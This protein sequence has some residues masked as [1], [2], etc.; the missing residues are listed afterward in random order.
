MNR[1]TTLLFA[2]SIVI[3]SVGCSQEVTPPEHTAFDAIDAFVAQ[4][5]EENGT[6]GLTLAVTSRDALLYVGTY[7]YADL[8]LRRPV[9]EET[10]FQIGSITKSFTALALMH[11]YDDGVFDPM[12]PVEDYLP[13]FSVRT[14]YAPIAG[15]HLLS[16]TAG[17]PANRDDVVGSWYMPWS[18]REQ[19]TAWP[20][21]E[22]FHY[23]NVG[24]QALH[25]LLEKL[26]GVDY[27]TYI[28]RVILEALD[29]HH[30]NP[31]IRL[32]SRTAQAVGYLQPYDDRPPH[33]SR[34]LVEAPF[35]EYGIGDGSIQTTAADMAAYARM[36]LNRGEGPRGRIVSEEAFELFATSHIAQSAVPGAIGYGYGMGVLTQGD[37]DYLAH[38][39]GMIGL[40]GYLLADLT[41]GFA[42]VL[43][44]NGPADMG[45]IAKYAIRVMQALSSG[46]DLPPMPEVEDPTR[47]EQAGDYAGLFTSTSGGTLE[48]TAAGGRLLMKHRRRRDRPG[49]DGK[50]LVLHPP[51]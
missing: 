35:A 40:Y 10:L 45:D 37:H 15:H 43:M 26:S 38:S 12:K 41:D 39:G 30:T 51:F 14:D 18:L 4:S 34:S 9:T 31:V 25:V 36:L 29:M 49:A 8:K 19:A 11:L 1:K 7:G 33:R 3:L 32:E 13:W 44:V 24:Y 21:G 47:V 27:G 17:I 28:S 16:H 50:G 48:F 2:L 42:V 5:M 20:P 46:A 22:K 23:S 6:P